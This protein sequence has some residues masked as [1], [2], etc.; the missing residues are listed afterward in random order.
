MCYSCSPGCDNCMPKFL[1]CP[2]CGHVEMLA[3]GECSKC[4]LPIDDAMRAAAEEEWRSGRRFAAGKRGGRNLVLD[5]LVA[6]GEVAPPPGYVPP[7][8]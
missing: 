8:E 1:E 4:G 3:R 5:R 6:A 2:H 7:S